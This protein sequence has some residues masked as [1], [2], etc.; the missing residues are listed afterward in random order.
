MQKKPKKS[1]TGLKKLAKITSQSIS[2]VYAGYKKNQKLK[3]L[4]N[5][6][7]EKISQKNN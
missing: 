2:S 5:A 1:E 6:R 3:K 7:I 4:E